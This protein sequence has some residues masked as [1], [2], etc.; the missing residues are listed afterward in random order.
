MN[1]FLFLLLFKIGNDIIAKENK[2]LFQREKEDREMIHLGM[3]LP[4]EPDR[5]WHLAAQAGV[6]NAVCKF[7]RKYSVCD[8]DSFAEAQKSFRAAGFE[9]KALEGDQF[10]MSRIKLGLPGRD[11][12]LEKYRVMLRNMGK[13]GI[14]ILCYNFM[15]GVGWFRS[16]SDI[17]YRGGALTSHWSR[18]DVPEEPLKFSHEK[19][20]ENYAYFL[21]AVLPA[22]EEAGVIM[23]LHPDDPPVPE[24]MGY[25]RIF[26]NADSYRRMLALADSPSAGITFCAATFRAMGED[27]LSLLR[28]W[29]E[30]IPF[31]H[32]RDNR[33]DADGFTETFHD[34]GPTD[35]VERFRIL[36]TFKHDVLVR[37]DHA[38]T[39]YGEDNSEPGYAA[40]GRIMAIEY[41]K[42]IL[43]TL[44]VEYK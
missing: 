28:E 6:E 23:C 5:R 29:Q 7:D 35:L 13:L 12:D 20:W 33:A 21:K 19:L 4:P 31:V 39:M 10:D 11:E 26:T 15:A 17:P 18:N 41:F 25:P 43:D 38:P 3:F 9:L 42:G 22:A 24:L 40:F 27:D 34:C 1:N 44:E 30:K 32:M 37:P 14:R 2:G 16:K 8:L 36:S